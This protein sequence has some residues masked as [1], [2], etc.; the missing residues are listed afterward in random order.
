MSLRPRSCLGRRGGMG[1]PRLVASAARGPLTAGT[2]E[3]RLCEEERMASKSFLCLLLPNP[4]PA[5]RPP[6]FET[7]TS[8]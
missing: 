8:L 7:V 3:W 4:L 1:G 6:V 2:K 5:H